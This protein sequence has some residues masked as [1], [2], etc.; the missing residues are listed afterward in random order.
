MACCKGLDPQPRAVIATSCGPSV[1]ESF[2]EQ[3]IEPRPQSISSSLMIHGDVSTMPCDSDFTIPV[4][5][6]RPT[7]HPFTAP[8]QDYSSSSSYSACG[9]ST[10]TPLTD[11]PS[12]SVI[13]TDDDGHDFDSSPTSLISQTFDEYAMANI[14]QVADDIRADYSD[15][16]HAPPSDS[17][18]SYSLMVAATVDEA[19]D[20]ASRDSSIVYA[21]VGGARSSFVDDAIPSTRRGHDMHSAGGELAWNF[22]SPMAPI[23]GIVSYPSSEDDDDVG[24]RWNHDRT[25]DDRRYQTAAYQIDSGGSSLY[26]TAIERDQ[27]FA[28]PVGLPHAPATLFDV[29]Q[30]LHEQS[31]SQ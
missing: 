8:M 11:D 25:L 3:S 10:T 22:Q 14:T 16:D 6:V 28:F 23:V 31:V 12:A 19:D 17:V 26:Q 15:I 20:I 9:S 29:Q 24:G 2:T 13:V 18:S 1:F 27:V 7:S 30:P 21:V 5:T 4:D